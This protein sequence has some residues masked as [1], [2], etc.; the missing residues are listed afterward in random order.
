MAMDYQLERQLRFSIAP[1]DK[2]LYSWSIGEF[3]GSGKQIGADQ[4][5]WVW[6]LNFTATEV[7][8]SDS[9]NVKS[10]YQG[11]GQP[12]KLE[13]AE[14]RIIRAQLRPGDSRD[15]ED[16]FRRA[17]YRMFGTDREVTNFTLDIIPI[18]DPTDVES[19]TAWGCPAYEAEVD[20]HKEPQPD[21]VCFYMRVRP[22]TFDRYAQRIADGTADELVLRLGGVEGF[23]S[24]WSPSIFTRDV[25]VLAPISEHV[26]AMPDGISAEPPRLGRIYEGEIYINA[27][28]VQARK[29]PSTND[30][31]AANE[32]TTAPLV[33]PEAA[34]SRIADDMDPHAVKL[35]GSIKQAV[36]VIAAAAI[37]TMI[38]TVF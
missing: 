34:M 29:L 16:W 21:I 22:E 37:I 12:D 36:W 8:L 35:L 7:V 4:I 18:T 10:G 38:A 17:K 19:C 26:V 27:K 3:D 9:I 13:V 32:P 25:K 33:R 1:E 15:D 2:S 28:R 30:E 24:E 11:E 31:E 20:F 6:S 14:R 5:P 23:Y